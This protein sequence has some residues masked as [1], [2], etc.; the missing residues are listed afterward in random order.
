M[1]ILV[2][3]IS[4]VMI[5]SACSLPPKEAKISDIVV[6]RVDYRT[7]LQDEEYTAQLICSY[8]ESEKILKEI[9]FSNDTIE[10]YTDEY[11]NSKG[12][13][14]IVVKTCVSYQYMLDKIEIIEQK[15]T[16]NLKENIPQSVE[17]ML[18]KKGIIIEVEKEEIIN[19]TDIDVEI[20]K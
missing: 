3:L 8:I 16:V 14:V 7:P 12:I 5:F 10:Y 4:C 1:R 18:C 9:G 20:I 15:L 13:I 11:Y 2:I 6:E 19:I 17:D